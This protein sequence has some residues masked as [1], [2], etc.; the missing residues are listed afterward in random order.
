[1]GLA[2]VQPFKCTETGCVL[3]ETPYNQ[4]F[5]PRV[6]LMCL[7]RSSRSTVGTMTELKDHLKLLFARGAELFDRQ[8]AQPVQHDT[9]E[10]IFETLQ[11]RTQADNLRLLVTFPVEMQVD[12]GA[13]DIQQWLSASGYTRVQREREGTTP[14]GP[15]KVLDVV[16]DR[17]RPQ[18]TERV[19]ISRCRCRQIRARAW[20]RRCGPVFH[21]E[22]RPRGILNIEVRIRR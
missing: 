6:W 21:N 2:T 19:R 3:S 7:V 14:S 18:G 11:A 22:W 5:P 16:A 4:A 8:T 10:T 9:V 20:P 15:R 17:F 12:A 1:M 13:D